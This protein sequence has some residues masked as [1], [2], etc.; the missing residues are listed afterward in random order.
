[1]YRKDITDILRKNIALLSDTD[2]SKYPYIPQQDSQLPRLNSLRRI[3]ELAKAIVFPG[4][5]G[6]GNYCSSMKE[7]FIGVRVEEL[8]GLLCEE[9][10]FGLQ[11]FSTNDVPDVQ[12]RSEEIA[13]KFI[14]ALPELKRVA[15]TD[16]KAVYDGDPAARTYEE[17][18]FCYPAIMA[19]H[20]SYP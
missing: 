2:S 3:I 7:Y 15:N 13:M 5:F 16:V 8:Y 4:Y 17:V 12:R 11:T 10:G 18:I 14:D 1:M 9:I 19:L 6:D 20:N